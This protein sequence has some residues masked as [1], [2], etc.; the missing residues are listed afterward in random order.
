MRSK[1]FSFEGHALCY[2]ATETSFTTLQPA[3]ETQ[4]NILHKKD[5]C[6]GDLVYLESEAFDASP[7][8]RVFWFGLEPS[9][10]MANVLTSAVV[11][12]GS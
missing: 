11:T 4:W 7:A 6:I 8:C 5:S 9:D 3:T 1:A 2:T 10:S 12:G